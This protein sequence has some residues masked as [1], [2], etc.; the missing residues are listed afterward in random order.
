MEGKEE[1][2][3]RKKRA[4]TN[5]KKDVECQMLR[6]FGMRIFVESGNKR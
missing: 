1:K 3:K 2:S 5:E 4:M 6:E